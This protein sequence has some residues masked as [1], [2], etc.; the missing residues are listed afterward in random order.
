MTSTTT[1]T[2]P[3][4]PSSSSIWK[5]TISELFDVF[6]DITST[7]NTSIQD[8]ITEDDYFPIDNENDENENNDENDI[9]EE[10][11]EQDDDD[12]D[13]DDTPPPP[14]P[15]QLYAVATIDYTEAFRIAYGLF[16]IVVVQQKE[17]ASYRTLLLTGTCLQLNPANYT[18]WHSRRQ[19]L[20]QLYPF[21]SSSSSS[22]NDTT[23][24]ADEN[25]DRYIR[26]I[27]NEL[28]IA[29][30]LGG[31]NPKNYQIWYHRRAVL[32]HLPP[33]LFLQCITDRS[34]STTT[35]TEENYLSTNHN[36]TNIT[37]L[38]LDYIHTVLSVD[39]KNYH[40]WSHRQWMVSH[41]I[42]ATSLCSTTPATTGTV[43]TNESHYIYD[44]EMLYCDHFIQLDIRNNSAWNH[45][46]YMVH[47]RHGHHNTTTTGNV[48]NTPLPLHILEQEVDYT[49]PIITM[50]PYNES[51]YKYLQALVR[52]LCDLCQAG[53]SN[54]DDN[55]NNSN[56]DVNSMDMDEDNDN[57][58]LPTSA[59]KPPMNAS[60]MIQN[61]IEQ[62]NSMEQ[63]HLLPTSHGT[64]DS[65]TTKDMDYNDTTTTT[66]THRI[67]SIHL[68]STLLE[69]Y[70]CRH[71]WMVVD[72]KR[73][74]DDNDEMTK[75]KLVMDE[76][77]AT[78]QEYDSIRS[79]YW[80]SRRGKP[81]S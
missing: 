54:D 33:W 3:P 66:P 7:T 12:D 68:C 48:T 79:Q 38:E 25:N 75:Y 22:D 77:I 51:P 73:N 63:H 58:R 64:S 59:T 16:R 36:V 78:L 69:I 2:S 80:Q 57:C 71:L 26:M 46:W 60:T 10:E 67:P 5:Y 43:A 19:C 53:T 65:D 52:E 42:T 4:I 13:D 47:H 1:T 49:I 35:S 50:D 32:E 9:D 31:N 14:Q 15:R 37:Y 24:P 6:A 55:Y 28:R 18:V 76:L 74:D 30:I 44:N 39:E 34:I 41:M 70:R 29:A 56:S 11:E 20:S 81:M 27:R 45:R 62:L 8:V 23:T 72:Q 40:A 61:V 21:P 17:L